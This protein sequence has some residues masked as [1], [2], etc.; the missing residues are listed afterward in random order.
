MGRGLR[1]LEVDLRQVPQPSDSLLP[2]VEGNLIGYT[3]SK[4]GRSQATDKA[5]VGVGLRLAMKLTRKYQ[6]DK[7]KN[8][9]K[10]TD[11]QPVEKN[12]VGEVRR[13]KKHSPTECVGLESYSHINKL[14]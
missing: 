4:A 10:Q 3:G 5:E 7:K 8:K 9:K 1:F 13:L 11:R 14:V 6:Q 2:G 12:V